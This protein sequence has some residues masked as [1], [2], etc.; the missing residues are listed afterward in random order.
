MAI[1]D[2][3]TI[4]AVIY[5]SVTDMVSL[6]LMHIGEWHEELVMIDLLKA[7]TSAYLTFI[8]SGQFHDLYPQYIHKSVKFQLECTKVIPSSVFA[9]LDVL[10]IHLEKNYQIELSVNIH[11]DFP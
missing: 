5:D 9:Y 3:D 1:E 6:I 8:S 4:D 11:Q 7:K 10:R 2:M